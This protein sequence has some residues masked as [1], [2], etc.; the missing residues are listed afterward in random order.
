M[1][2][3]TSAAARLLHLARR[4]LSPWRVPSMRG[5]AHIETDMQEKRRA[6]EDRYV[7]ERDAEALKKLRERQV[8]DMEA[9]R[10]IASQVAAAGLLHTAGLL[11][12]G[13]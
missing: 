7:R 11:A 3:T 8:Q 2:P 9:L 5:M 6:D 1:P 13:R 12:A 10:S 4:T